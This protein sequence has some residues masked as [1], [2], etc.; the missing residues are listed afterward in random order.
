MLIGFALC[1][2]LF[3]VGLVY[4]R[5]QKLRYLMNFA[6][7]QSLP[8]FIGNFLADFILF[9]FPTIAFIILLFAM[10]IEAFSG[11]EPTIFLIILCFGVGLIG[12]TYFVSYLFIDSTKAFQVIGTLYIVIGFVLPI[13]LT[14]LLA[15]VPN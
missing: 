3:I 13:A 12:M 5:E 15:N 2:G 4:D 10:N 11:Y 1:S 9:L 7:L 6:G 14:S 8:Y